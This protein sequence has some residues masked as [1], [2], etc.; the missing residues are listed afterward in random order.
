MRA[1]KN[2]LPLI[3]LFYVIRIE[4]KINYNKKLLTLNLNSPTGGSAYGMPKKE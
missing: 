2:C 3:I 4:Y 1:L